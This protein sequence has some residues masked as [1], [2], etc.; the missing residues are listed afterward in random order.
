MPSFC[1]RHAYGSTNVETVARSHWPGG[2][3]LPENETMFSMD[4]ISP[5]L[6]PIIVSPLLQN[7]FRVHLSPGLTSA[8][9]GIHI[10]ISIFEQSPEKQQEPCPYYLAASNAIHM[11]SVITPPLP[12]VRLP[13]P[14]LRQ[15]RVSSRL[16]RSPL[17]A[18][19]RGRDR[20]HSPVSR[21][22]DTHV[23]ELTLQPIRLCFPRASRLKH[24]L[25]RDRSYSA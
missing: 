14:L 2:L 19:H 18:N 8:A 13:Y 11:S 12:C 22:A 21:K 17:G 3:S 25:L 5:M 23:S 10:S 4:V 1:H 15:Q 7:A 16:F 6:G 9:N 20:F 24:S